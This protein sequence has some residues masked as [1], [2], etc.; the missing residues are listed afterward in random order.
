ML[1][2]T[3]MWASPYGMRSIGNAQ[4]AGVG[5]V[6]TVVGASFDRI[7]RDVTKDVLVE[8]YAPV[9]CSSRRQE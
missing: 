1:F 6:V 5:V 8:F 3:C 4:P 7:V 9:R 2:L